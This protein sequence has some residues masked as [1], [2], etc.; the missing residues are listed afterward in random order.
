MT[1]ALNLAPLTA[2]ALLADPRLSA[3][4]APASHPLALLPVRLETRYAGDELL[5]RIYPDQVHVDAHDPR[6]SA[7]E[8]QAGKDFWRLQWRTG[9]N[10]ARQQRAWTALAGRYGAGR[11]GW[12]VRATRPTNPDRRPTTEVADDAPLPAEPAFPAVEVSDDRR[13]PVARLL[14][15]R[16]TVTAY[17]G[18][19]VVAVASGAPITADPPVGPDLSAPLVAAE[20]DHETA[21][22]DAGMHWLVD[23]AEAERLGLAVRLPVSTP[24]DLLLATGVGGQD[25]SAG[26]DRLAALLAAQRYSAG[27][28]LLLPETPTN[29]SEA[30]GS[31]WASTGAGAWSAADVTPAPDSA[32]SAAARALGVDPELVADLPNAGDTDALLAAAMGRALWPATWGYWLTQF[33]GVDA[34][35]H[36]WARDFARRFLRPEG[37]LPTLRVGRQPYGLLPVTALGRYAGDERTTRLARVLAG[38]RQEGWRPAVDLAPR[39]GRSDVASDL[40]DVLRLEGRSDDL[41][42]RRSMGARF[43]DNLQRF[44]FREVTGGGF[45]DAA[46]DRA[47]PLARAAGL[48]LLPG[49]LAVHEPS[50]H[51]VTLPL[52]SSGAEVGFIDALLAADLDALA[53]GTDAPES[54]LAALLRHGLLREHADAAARLLSLGA[55]DAELYG[56]G[57]DVTGWAARRA[58]TLPEGDTVAARLAGGTVP[59]LADFRAA[60]GTLAQAPVPVLERHLLGALDATSHRLDAWVTALATARLGQ[61]RAAAPDGVLVGGYGWVEGVAPTAGPAATELPADEP[62]PL[63]VAADDPGFIHAPSV[64]QAQVAALARNAH[65]AHG[66]APTDPFAVS[67][68]SQ[69]VRLARWIFDGVR[70]GRSLGAVLGY[71]VE[72]DLHERDLDFAIGP[73]RDV[74][75]LPGQE[76]LPAEAR[77]LDGLRLHELWAAGEDHAVDHL[78]AMNH[79]PSD[80]ER[81]RAVA[82]L[83]GLN[84]AV[85]AAADALQAEQVH[86]FARGDLS[87]A[88]S[89]VADLDRGLAPPPDLDFLAT[90]RTGAA[91]THRVLVLVDPDAS[92]AAGWTGPTADPTAPGSTAEPADPLRLPALSARAAAEPALD[93]WLGSLLGHAS[94]RTLT[95]AGDPSVAVPLPDLRLAAADF[96][97]LAGGGSALRE[98]AARAAVAAG[99]D[100]A[101]AELVP[102]ADLLALLELGGSLAALVSSATALDGTGLQPPHA[103]PLPGVDVADLAAR[104]AAARRA[105]TAAS[106]RLADALGRPDDIAGLQAAVVATWSLAVGEAGVPTAASGWPA[107]AVRV[108]ADLSARL[109]APVAASDDAKALGR[110]LATLQGPGF[111]AVPRFVVTDPAALI[112]SR[113]DPG[114]TGGNPLAAEVWLTRMERVREPLARLGIALREA[115]AL[116]GGPDAVLD[117]TVA[118]VPHRAGDTWNALPAE[119]YV[120][121]AA[122]LLVV[123]GATLRPG[124]ALAGLLIDEWAEVVPAASET[125]GVAFRY[126]PP[127]SMAPQAILL[128]VPPVLDEPWTVA[129]LNQVLVETLELTH[130]RVV[131]PEALGAARQYLPAAVLAY[132][133]EGDAPSTDPNALTPAGG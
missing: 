132:N 123:G 106:D 131:P 11:A 75:P 105:V 67:L 22:V 21:A 112:A 16:W 44:L 91:V 92:P 25:A 118:Q 90:P 9:T 58:T 70:A 52:V 80:S 31:G 63:L 39:V 82:V 65:L 100:V 10:L 69:R 59:A 115:D 122:S 32:G 37:P 40:V 120:D 29:N 18:G 15:Q 6:L 1:T 133:A 36:D 76:S 47:L 24:V 89:S 5:V 14:P 99:R 111:L 109:A 33:V 23:F 84:A 50:A 74:A 124:A 130:L 38:V 43:A 86:Q 87:R 12:V 66:G 93:A 97:Q 79:T 94:G 34:A 117:L 96:V 78:V 54:V 3:P 72:R 55:A 4:L 114:M 60:L 68:T 48:G 129:S 127:E 77:R 46:R 103:D 102:D 20:D 98:L 45:W 27:L 88:V 104:A 13:T 81:S 128:A 19:Q 2:D 26:A 30:S 107:A 95:L 73:A 8:Q 85:D 41:R 101:G 53:L 56:F 116:R 71:L 125:T 61:L 49:A 108:L 64:Q 17:A 28:G 62:G 126:D 121:A 119:H 57:D 7:A 35:G 51:P 83:R 113:D 110:E 42:L